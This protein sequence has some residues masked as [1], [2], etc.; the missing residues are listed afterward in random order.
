MAI[1]FTG[2]VG[3]DPDT[4]KY[5]WTDVIFIDG[6][7]VDSHITQF[8][9]NVPPGS[10]DDIEIDGIQVT[11][12]NGYYDHFNIPVSIGSL[13]LESNSSLIQSTG[14]VRLSGT[15]I[16]NGS[17][18]STAGALYVTDQIANAGLMTFGGWLSAVTDD[19]T[20]VLSGI[21]DLRLRGGYITGFGGESSVTDFYNMSTISG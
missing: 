12:A 2:S 11:I 5:E 17:Y 1:Q 10:S 7:P 4:G 20:F 3:T 14:S 9:G 21:G 19:N 8:G 15:F 6:D 16:N 18:T 13:L